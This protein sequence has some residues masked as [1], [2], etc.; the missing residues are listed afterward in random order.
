M[1]RNLVFLLFLFLSGCSIF[2]VHFKIHNPSRAGRYPKRTEEVILLGNQDSRFRNCYDVNYYNLYVSF[3]RNL[4]QDN[5]IKGGV[6]VSANALADLDTVQIDLAEQMKIDGINI[7]KYFHGERRAL[8]AKYFRKASAVF[9]VVPGITKGQSFS[10]TI[11]FFGTPAEA[12]RPPWAGGFVR[13][14]D[15]LKN[16]WWGVACEANGASLWWPC[17]D[18]VN[19]EPDSAD[20]TLS[21][22][23][24][25]IAVSNGILTEHFDS[26]AEDKVNDE[27]FSWHVSYPINP[28]NITFYVGKYKLLHDTYYSNVTHDTLQLNHYVLAQHYEKAKK[29][30]QQLKEHLAFYEETFGAYPWYR[31]G[32]KLVESPYAGMEHQTAIAYGNGFQNDEWGFDYIILHETAHEW[33]G[34]AVTATDLADAWIHEGFATYAEALFVEKKFGHESYLRYLQSQR[35]YIINRRPVVAPYGQRYFNYKDG[36]IYFKGSWVLHSLRYS[37]NNDSLFFDILKTFYSEYKYKNATSEDFE[38]IVSEKTGTS[39]KW[40]FD[41]YLRNRFVPELEYYLDDGI[42]YSRWNPEYSDSTFRMRFPLPATV[43]A[44]KNVIAGSVVTT[45]ISAAEAPG[46]T[47]VIFD[48]RNFLFKATENRSLAKKFR[49]GL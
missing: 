10:F 3:G 1:N 22:P 28:Y 44:G 37:I 18:V 26:L 20:I 27:I 45:S 40:F 13:K 46:V 4:A 31:D 36:D 19:D 47:N 39:Y 43:P 2:G 33:W 24:G 32:F 17:K 16:P 35:L 12:K 48:E 6:I 21:V 14:T 15:D 42:L 23:K 34:N 30:F 41:Q 5:Q 7:I 49:K 25:F 38:R 11:S 8:E 29:H 9:I